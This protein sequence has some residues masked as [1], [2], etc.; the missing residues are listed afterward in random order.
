VSRAPSDR[1]QVHRHPERGIYDRDVVDAILDEAL[2][3]HVA[4]VTPEGGPRVIPTIHVRVGDTLYIHG[5]QASRTLRAA[6][7]DIPLCIDA[8]IVDGIVL[9][10]STPKHSLNYRS[11]VVYGVAREVT[12][13]G[14]M[15]VAQRALVEHVVPGRTADA[16]MPS[17]KELQETAILAIVLDEASAKIRTG[18][19]IDDAADIDL[20][21]WAGVLPLRLEIGEPEPA[22]GLPD[23]IDMPG[24]LSSYGRTR[25]TA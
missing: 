10:R 15:D 12:D 20:P 3:C 19:P 11:A 18:G 8:T 1:T 13:P 6:R 7:T 16:R 22:P 23:G 25:P 2:I 21:I 17:D 24:Y 9:A 5:S 14:E 4:W